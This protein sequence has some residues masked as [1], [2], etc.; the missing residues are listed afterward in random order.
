MTV[1]TLHMAKVAEIRIIFMEY[2]K[3]L[4]YVYGRIYL[5]KNIICIIQV[6]CC[7]IADKLFHSFYILIILKIYLEVENNEFAL[8]FP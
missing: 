5:R 7:F 6:K 2:M 3:A 4:S 1:V 8:V